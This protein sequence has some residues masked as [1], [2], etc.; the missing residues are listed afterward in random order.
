MEKPPKHQRRLGL[1]EREGEPIATEI[2]CIDLYIFL[3]CDSNRLHGFQILNTPLTLHV[4][5]MH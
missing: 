4:Q 2:A 3:L 1:R 5:K